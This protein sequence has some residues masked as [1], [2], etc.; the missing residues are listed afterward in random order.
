MKY[1]LLIYGDDSDP[2]DTSAPETQDI[3]QAYQAFT[4]E[5]DGRDIL[6]GSNALQ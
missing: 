4:D 1:L 5:V 6:V 2:M 3:F